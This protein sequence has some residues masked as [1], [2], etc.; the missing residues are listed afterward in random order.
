MPRNEVSVV[1]E[2]I[3]DRVGVCWVGDKSPECKVQ[4]T[5]RDRGWFR[6]PGVTATLLHFTSLRDGLGD[7]NEG[8]LNF[9]TN[10]EI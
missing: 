3:D 5:A 6:R 4:I 7:L 1:G 10:Q 9:S 8:R 2:A